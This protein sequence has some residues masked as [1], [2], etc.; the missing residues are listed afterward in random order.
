MKIRF[1]GVR[2]SIPTPGKATVRYGG[3]T[4]CVE[5]RPYDDRR[6]FIL[7]S[8]TGI[9]ELGLF[10]MKNDLPGGSIKADI[11]ISHTHWDHLH[12]FPFF[13]PAFIPGNEFTI[14]GPVDFDERL[15]DLFIGQMKY[16]YFPVKL[17]QM[18]A[19]IRFEELN[20]TQM[21]LSGVKITTKYLNHPVLVL[22][23]RFEVDGKT[24]VYSTDTEPYY[25]V[26][27]G[28]STAGDAGAS[29]EDEDPAIAEADRVVA[30]LNDKHVEFCRNAD[31]LI[32]DTQY[33]AAEYPKF[34]SWGHT[35]MEYALGTAARANVKKLV[36][37][38]HDPTRSDDELDR[39]TQ[40]IAALARAQHGGNVEVV[41]ASEG[42]E[43]DL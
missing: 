13:V 19:N 26:F 14:R 38:H 34:V 24:L 21:E 18:S 31:L 15:E 22:G 8:G 41:A 7:D 40:R 27:R 17:E 30:E 36:M 9:R 29:G 28:P 2:G 43:I 20:E 5:V 39:E 33:T 4:A 16:Q 10:L 35:A 1:W 12:G 23:Y 3:N 25:N 42:L 11:F 37:W 6:L 32:H